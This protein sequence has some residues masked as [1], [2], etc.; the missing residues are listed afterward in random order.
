MGNNVW[1]STWCIKVIGHSR[2]PKPVTF[3]LRLGAQP[4]L[5]KCVLFAWEWKTISISKPEHLRLPTLVFKQRP[6]GNRKWPILVVTKSSV[7][8]VR[9]P[10]HVKWWEIIKCEV[11]RWLVNGFQLISSVPLFQVGIPFTSC[12]QLISH[13]H[14][15]RRNSV[16]FLPLAEI[17][18]F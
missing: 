5:W 3:K 8:E 1:L 7:R 17:E 13:F 12:F 9:P 14:W 4:F 2:V 10:L 16:Y 15:F 6:G 11:L 18:L